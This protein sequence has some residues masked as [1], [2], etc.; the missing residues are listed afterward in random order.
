MLDFILDCSNFDW[1]MLSLWHILKLKLVSSH[2]CCQ[3]ANRRTSTSEKWKQWTCNLVQTFKNS[4]IMVCQKKKIGIWVDDEF[5]REIAQK[6]KCVSSSQSQCR[7]LHCV[8]TLLFCYTLS[9]CKLWLWLIQVHAIAV[10]AD[11]WNGFALL[12]ESEPTLAK[13]CSQTGRFSRSSALHRMKSRS[14][15]FVQMPYSYSKTNKWSKDLPDQ[16]ALFGL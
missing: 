1:H 9:C 8:L 11:T 15:R 14:C 16:W 7:S 12:S 3:S 13:P 10:F 6:I 2:N 5:Q 4:L